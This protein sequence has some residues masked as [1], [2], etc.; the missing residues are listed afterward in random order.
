MSLG[1]NI[2][3]WTHPIVIGSLIMSVVLI[4]LLLHTEKKAEEPVMPL[5]LILAPPRS[6]LIFSNFFGAATIGTIFFNLPLYFQTVLLESAT[7]AGGRLLIPSIAGTAASVATGLIIDRTGRLFPVLFTGSLILFVGATALTCMDRVL[8]KW[9]YVLFLIPSNLGLGFMFPSTLMSVLATSSQED[10]AVATSTL[11][12]WRCLGNV[13]GVASSSLIVQNCLYYFLE[14]R[15]TGPHKAEIID[16]VRKRVAA[17]F[18]LPKGTQEEVISSYAS[19]LKYTFVWSTLT[20]AA[21][22][23]LIY[24]V[25]LPTLRS[26][27]SVKKEKKLK[28]DDYQRFGDEV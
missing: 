3:P 10:Q 16:Q 23:V 15:V 4:K 19:S 8:P 28:K 12:L 14:K 1:G 6:K 9:T 20:A 2:F 7:V 17:I 13:I 27:G 11:I 26:P 18:D 22:L 21:A 5:E 24:G 25:H